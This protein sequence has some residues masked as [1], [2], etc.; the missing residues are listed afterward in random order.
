VLLPGA[1]YSIEIGANAVYDSA[2]NAFASTQV[3]N[4]NAAVAPS[5]GGAGNDTLAGHA[6]GERIDGGAGLDTVIYSG[7]SANY[8]FTRS[9]DQYIVQLS[10]AP[11]SS[12]DTLTGVERV[13]FQDGSMRALDL[14]GVA[15]Q[16]YR[17]YQAAFDRAPDMRG[18]G[19]WMASMEHGSSLHDVAQGFVGS[20]E[21]KSTYGAAPAARDFV[22]HLYLN[23]LDRPGEQAGIDF[24]V[25]AMTSGISYADVLAGFSESPEN[26]ASVAKVIGNGFTFL[27]YDWH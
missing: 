14:D 3:L 6:T 7:N 26:Q 21:F 8:T 12:A 25:G 9:G 13:A 17:L 18:V 22:E 1:R 5:T 4:F 24:W 11:A 23:V 27:P 10:G 20:A 19:F 2:G 16:T 15:G